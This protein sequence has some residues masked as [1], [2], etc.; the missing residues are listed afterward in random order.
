MVV[1]DTNIIIDHLRQSPK[2]Q[3]Y[4]KKL[5]K[6]YNE[7]NLF[8]SIITIQEIYEGK[9][10]AE[11]DKEE[12][13]LSTISYL[14]ILPYT[15]EVAQLA[16]EIA[17]DSSNAIDLADAAIAATAIINGFDLFTLYKKDFVGIGN[18]QLID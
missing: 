13:F 3:T 18:L 1:L 2:K 7:R 14:K 9:N 6:K 17:R 4:L 11:K 10:I 5:V 8:I 16:G 12:K 15:F